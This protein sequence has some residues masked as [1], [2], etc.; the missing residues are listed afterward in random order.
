MEKRIKRR[1]GALVILGMLV[2]IALVAPVQAPI[3]EK[4]DMRGNDAVSG[5]YLGTNNA[6]DL[7]IRTSGN[8]RMVVTA[9]GVLNVDSGTLYVDNT[10]NR[11]GI[12]DTSP[13][14]KLEVTG[15]SGDD[16]FGV[17][18]TDDNNDNGDIF[19]IDDEGKVGIGTASP[20]AK[21][22]VEVS[23]GGAA[24]LGSS[25]CVA[26]G[27]YSVAMGDWTSATEDYAVAMGYDTTASGLASVAM[28][29]NAIANGQGSFANGYLA[30]ANGIFSTA[31]GW[32]VTSSGMCSQAIGSFITAGPAIHTHVIGVGWDNDYRI[33]NNIAYSL[34]V[35]YNSDTPTLFV[36][37][38]NGIGTTGNIGIATT[39]PTAKVHIIQT[40]DDTDAFRIDDADS[41]NTPFVIDKDGRVGIGTASPG[42]KLEIKSSGT[43]M[44]SALH[45]KNSA[46]TSLLFVRDDGNV[47]IGDRWEYS[48]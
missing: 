42:S 39:S 20:G 47:G 10:N 36:G 34:M 5:D 43:Q 18:S 14:F 30:L 37:P 48:F 44:G 27:D 35:G 6:Q 13:D 28:G 11:V 2:S 40:D 12:G 31:N 38:S 46:S 19:K 21:L 22:D 24:T 26:T 25:N 7:D 16:Y 45:V 29:N 9:G 17:S 41:D 15:S 4:W 23:S 32:M 1:I 3:G 33:V 8:S